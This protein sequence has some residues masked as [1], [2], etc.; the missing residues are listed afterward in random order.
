MPSFGDNRDGKSVVVRRSPARACTFPPQLLGSESLFISLVSRP[1]FGSTDTLSSSRNVRTS[2]QLL[3]PADKIQ[4]FET[5]DSP[6]NS[7][8][9]SS[10]YRSRCIC[11]FP[12]TASGVQFSRHRVKCTALNALRS[13]L[14][15]FFFARSPNAVFRCKG[16][17][18][19]WSLLCFAVKNVL[20]PATD[21]EL[22]K[23]CCPRSE[24]HV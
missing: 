7:R 22:Y 2:D 11:T 17:Q 16:E 6:R 4:R 8:I 12:R 3:R 13:R 14:P 24:S 5:R 15:V 1:S 20:A 9:V 21:Y 19:D 10:L 18:T 23:S